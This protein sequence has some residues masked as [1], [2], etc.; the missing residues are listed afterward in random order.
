MLE[1]YIKE[2]DELTAEVFSENF[3]RTFLS[4]KRVAIKDFIEELT[5]I[6]EEGEDE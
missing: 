1:K 5:E 3:G 4:G 2:Y 6:L